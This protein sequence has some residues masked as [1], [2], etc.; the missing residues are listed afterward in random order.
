MLPVD[1]FMVVEAELVPGSDALKSRVN[2]VTPS[3]CNIAISTR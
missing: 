2:P 1:E 3:E